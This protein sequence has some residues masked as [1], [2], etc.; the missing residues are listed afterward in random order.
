[1]GGLESVWQPAVSVAQAWTSA[2]AECGYQYRVKVKEL[3]VN[4]F[5][6]VPQ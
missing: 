5:K 3:R 1:M 2:A 4:A 6:V